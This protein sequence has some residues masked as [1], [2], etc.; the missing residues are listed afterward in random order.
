MPSYADEWTVEAARARY[1]EANNFAPDGGYDADWV[2]FKVGPFPVI[3]PNTAGRK[4]AVPQH[5]L[6]H[7][8]TAY[9]TNLVG[10]A[11]IGAWEIA[12][13][14]FQV[15]AAWILNMLVQ[16]PVIFF[17][18]PR[19]YRAFVRGRHSRN[20][21][22][23]PFSEPMLKKYVGELREDLGLDAPTREAT[24]ADKLAFV[25][26]LA[27]AIAIQIVIAIVFFGVPAWWLGAFD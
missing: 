26:F 2:R 11:E 21:Y 19:A 10:E 1:F 5:D 13:G 14:C 4:A 3:F 9:D 22:D 17:A 15:R 25:R 20:L 8:A 23:G 27:T 12:S 16:W 24:T 7:L 6:H 18:L